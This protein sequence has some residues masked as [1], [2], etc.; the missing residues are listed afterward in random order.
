[1]NRYKFA[2]VDMSYVLMRNMFAIRGSKGV[3]EYHEGEVI[4]ITIQTMN[5]IARDFGITADKVIFVYD[6]WDKEIGGYFRTHILKGEY[7]STRVY[8]TEQL[9]EE[10]RADETKTAEEIKKAEEDLYFNNVK[11]KAKWGMVRDL[12][13][14][15]IP[16]LG[17]DGWEF[18]DLAYLASCVLYGTSD[19]PSVIITKDSDLLYSLSPQMDYFRIPVKGSEPK[20]VTYDEMWQTIPDSLKGSLSLYQYKSYLDSLGEGHNDMTKTMK[21]GAKADETILQILK[22]DYS[23]VEDVELLERQLST[24]DIEKFPR[25]NEAL[26][27]VNELFGTA[28]RLGSVQDFRAFCDKYKVDGISD[29]YF[30]EFVSRFDTKLFTER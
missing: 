21:E 29:R 12:K 2:L 27:I 20:V 3:G 10:Y 25:F 8:M 16:C 13:N 23:N 7:K 19:K 5:K 4:R 28:G 18:D 9:L 24:F 14:I 6:K 26:R 11:Y 17:L 30:T 15:G 22:G 1:M